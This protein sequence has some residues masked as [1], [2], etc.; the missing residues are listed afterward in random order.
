MDRV[1]RVPTR[2]SRKPCAASCASLLIDGGSRRRARW[3]RK[4]SSATRW[5]FSRRC[6][7]YL[8]SKHTDVESKIKK[9]DGAPVDN[10]DEAL[11]RWREHF[12]AILTIIPKFD[13]EVIRN[14][15]Q[16]PYAEEIGKPPAI[17][18][19]QF[20]LG[21][22]KNRK[23]TG[24][25]KVPGELLKFGGDEV[26]KAVHSLFTK[27]WGNGE[28]PS[29]FKDS[30]IIA[31]PKKGD[32]TECDNWRGNSLL[33]V[34]GKALTTVIAQRL[35]KI[36]DRVVQE[37]QNGFRRARST[38]DGVHIL[39]R[40]VELYDAYDQSLHISFVD[41]KKFYGTMPRSLLWRV[42]ARWGV[43]EKLVEMVQEIHEGAKA[44]V[45]V[46][47]QHTE[48]FEVSGGLR[49]GCTLAP[50]LAILYMAATIHVWQEGEPRTVMISHNTISGRMNPGVK[51]ARR[52]ESILD[53]EYADDLK[54]VQTT[55][56]KS[57]QSLERFGQTSEA[58]GLTV[59]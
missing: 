35:R 7:T 17:E 32:P 1:A 42:L 50:C 28:V 2:E 44:V 45:R 27:M 31:L 10:F 55:A 8:A 30:E 53:S 56:E 29:A 14:I 13:E 24:L 3:K 9:K 25:D 20:A 5:T 57:V 38:I 43:P 48:P 40:L 6:R 46:D 16:Q 52:V 51:R 36:V 41:M 18:E 33:S 23:A 37:T 21:R 34:G 47:G 4:D 12:Q 19:V 59:A 58:F 11:Q 26:T 49:Q 22:L 15:P 39:R 54:I